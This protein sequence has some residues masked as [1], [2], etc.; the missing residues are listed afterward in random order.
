MVLATLCWLPNLSLSGSDNPASRYQPD[1]PGRAASTASLAGT[2]A[3]GQASWLACHNVAPL[4]LSRPLAAGHTYS[5]MIVQTA[6]CARMNRRW[7]TKA[8]RR[9]E[10]YCTSESNG[11]AFVRGGSGRARDPRPCAAL[12]GVPAPA[13]HHKLGTRACDDG[14]AIAPC[15]GSHAHA[16]RASPAHTWSYQTRAHVCQTP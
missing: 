10:R 1:L 12:C 11:N 5:L 15:R 9:A 13:P 16:G 3:P 14:A 8:L 6:D 4:P 2:P 7:W